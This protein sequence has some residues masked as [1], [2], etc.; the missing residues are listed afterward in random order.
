MKITK[1]SPRYP[2]A[3]GKIIVFQSYASVAS[4]YQLWAYAEYSMLS[5]PSQ[6]GERSIGK[7]L[8]SS[9]PNPWLGINTSEWII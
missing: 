9:L 7:T 2:S 8:H 4:V 5:N 1:N 3:S 6:I